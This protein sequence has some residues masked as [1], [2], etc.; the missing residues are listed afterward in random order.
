MRRTLLNLGLALLLT[1]LAMPSSLSSSSS[2]PFRPTDSPASIA[3]L[4][5]PE[6]DARAFLPQGLLSNSPPSSISMFNLPRP[7]PSHHQPTTP[8]SYQILPRQ[9]YGNNVSMMYG[10]DQFGRPAQVSGTGLVAPIRPS[11]PSASIEQYHPARPLSAPVEPKTTT[12]WTTKMYDEQ[13][14]DNRLALW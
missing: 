2:S 9:N 14:H 11:T 1:G 13:G 6:D 10:F 12:V 5:T 3:T 4:S 7:L 8:Q